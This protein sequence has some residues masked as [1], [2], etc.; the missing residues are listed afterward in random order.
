[1]HH[2]DGF[3]SARNLQRIPNGWM[4]EGLLLCK[5]LQRGKTV[6][7][8]SESPDITCSGADYFLSVLD[9]F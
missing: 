2:I 4:G 7:W 6:N 9:F 5:T 3:V 1:M 8:L